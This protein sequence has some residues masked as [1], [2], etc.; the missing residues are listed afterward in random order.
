M[1]RDDRGFEQLDLQHVPGRWRP[2]S[3]EDCRLQ[4]AEEPVRA[5]LRRRL[6]PQRRHGRSAPATAARS[7]RCRGRARCAASTRRRSATA[8][9]A[10]TGS[11]PTAR[12]PRASPAHRIRTW[13]AAACRCP[14]AST[15]ARP[16]SGNIAARHDRLVERVHGASPPRR[17]LAERGLRRHGHQQRLRRHQPELRRVRWQRQPPV[18]RAGR[19]RQHPVCGA[20]APRR[21][22]TR[23]RWP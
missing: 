14:A 6:P 11:S 4:V 3:S 13:P 23:C 10:R 18:L 8:A 9:R 1:Q 5:A 16:S 20:P 12:S 17:P 19:Q 7:T 22:T 2:D 21:A 15:C